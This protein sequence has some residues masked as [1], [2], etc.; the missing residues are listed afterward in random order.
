MI[1][2]DHDD[3]L[4][5]VSHPTGG[6]LVPVHPVNVRVNDPDVVHDPPGHGVPEALG[7]DVAWNGIAHDGAALFPGTVRV[8]DLAEQGALTVFVRHH[9]AGLGVSGVGRV[10]QAGEVP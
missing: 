9:R 1:D 2:L 10:K 7:D 3:V 8:V 4:V 6:N 5:E